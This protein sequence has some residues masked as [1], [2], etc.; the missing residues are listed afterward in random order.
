ML[1]L[2]GVLL[3]A[4][5]PCPFEPILSDESNVLLEAGDTDSAGSAADCKTAVGVLAGSG[6]KA[7]AAFDALSCKGQVHQMHGAEYILSILPL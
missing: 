1:S 2:T 3:I 4:A 6:C 7:A 5:G